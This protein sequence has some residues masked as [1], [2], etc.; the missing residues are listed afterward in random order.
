MKKHLLI[1]ASLVLGIGQ[2]FAD[3]YTFEVANLK[4]SLP[5]DNSKIN[6]PYTWKVSEVPVTVTL[7]KADGSTGTMNVTS[8]VTLAKNYTVT[9]SVPGEGTIDHVRITADDL[10]AFTATSPTTGTCTT[11]TTTFRWN[12]AEGESVSSVVFTTTSSADVTK[13]RVDYTPD[14]NY[15]PDVPVAEPLLG[16]FEATAID[17]IGSYTGTDPYVYDKTSKKYYALNNLGE[18]E[19]FGLYPEVSTLKVAGGSATQIEYIATV[20][21]NGTSDVPYINTNYIPKANTRIV[22][23]VDIAESSA[24]NWMAV[25]G[26]RQGGWTSHAFVLFART[27]KDN[28]Y[29]KGCYNRTGDEHVGTTEIPRDQ[30]MIIDAF[31]NTVTFSVNETEAARIEANGT[32]EDCTNNL[33]LFDTNTGGVG[34]NRRDNSY[35]FM[36]L[37]GCKIYEGD[38]LVRDFVP[39]VTAEGKG[40]LKDKV[41]GEIVL[42]ASN[43][44]FVL[45]PDGQTIASQAGIS[46]YPGKFVINTNDNHE[47]NWN[48]TDWVDLGAITYEAIDATNYQDMRREGNGGGWKCRFGYDETYNHIVNDGNNNFFNPYKGDGNWEPYQCTV[49][50]FTAGDAYRVSFKFSSNGWNSWS[51]YTELP[52][53]V[54]NNPEFDRALVPTS[55]SGQ[56]LGFVGLPNSAVENQPYS[57]KFIA[58]NTTATLAIQ[59]GVGDD[60]KDFFFRFNELTIDHVVY[61]E[62]YAI[63]VAIEPTT[64]E[65]VEEWDGTSDIILGSIRR[66]GDSYKWAYT[67]TFDSGMGYSDAH[68]NEIFGVPADD[69]NGKAWYDADYV[70]VNSKTESWIF[71]NNV[72][73]GNWPSNMGEVYVR[74][75]FK[76]EGELPE[77][78]YMPACHDDAPCEYYINGTLVWARNGFEPGVNGWYEDEIVKLNAEQRA[79]IKTDGSVN[80]F[81]YHVHQNWGGRYA[82]GGIYGNSMEEGSPSARFENN[83][84]RARLAVAIAQTEG[85]EGIDPEVLEY[86]QNATVCLQDAGRALNLIRYELRKALSPRHDYSFDSAEPADGLECWLYNVGAGQFLAGSNNWGTHTSLDYNISAWPMVLLANSSGENRYSIKTNLPNGLRG[87]NDGLGHNGYVDCGY[88]DDFTTNEGWAWTFEAVGNGNYRI[89]QSGLEAQEGKYLGMTDGEGY[90]VDTDKAGADNPYNQWKVV[91]RE[92]LEALAAEATAE[93]P[94]D[95]SYYIHQNTFSQNDF[96]GDNKDNANANLNDSKWECNAGEIFNWKGNDVNGDYV[97]NMSNAEGKV[98]IKQVITGLPAGQYVVECTGFYRDGSYDDAIAGNNRQL[99]YFYAGSEDNCT[100]LPSILDGA[101]LGAG[102]GRFNSTAIIPDNCAQAPRFFKLGTYTVQTPVVNVGNGEL[103]IGVY[104]NAEDVKAN[105]WIVLDNFRLYRVGDAILPTVTVSEDLY[106]TYVAPYDVDFTGAEVSAYA[107]QANKLKEGFV[108]LAPVTTVPAGTAVV[109]KAEAAGTYEINFAK[110]AEL[111]ADNDLVAAEEDVVASGTQY[112]LANGDDGIGFYKA[113]VGST[114]A[115]GKGYLVLSGEGVKPYYGFE[116]NATG[117]S[118]I[119]AAEDAVIYNLAG[120]RVSKAA[121]GVNIVNGK[122]VLK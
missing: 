32:V 14:E 17:A 93:N 97:F 110:D 92:Q 98:Y 13:I 39:I 12:P 19:E 63:D 53:F 29:N 62:K 8:S 41:T 109:V 81:A 56:V 33:F 43:K 94:A 102:Y 24:K 22:M 60:F 9:V 16:P 112:V 115:A 20:E 36:K 91:T 114:I 35:M 31:E 58:D 117:I 3:T 47:Y 21:A 120:Q 73:P 49:D 54:I 68:F 37:Y 84:T 86:A 85:V 7:A 116:N 30:R 99:A 118:G 15:I 48:G 76:A 83:E 87:E 57:F 2:L 38:A 72:L 46:V 90:Q 50:G 100:L 51:S 101:N 106:A 27:G 119:N 45:S 77:Q 67:M 5:A 1:L 121:K 70:M 71:G 96:D 107:A 105:D 74:R 6:L 26:A 23:D 52:F 88:G 65:Y 113:I 66:S 89:I 55:A 103:E 11:T 40:G 78:L 4:A 95:I 69:N 42:S 28:G 104:R 25:F 108:H 64:A 111:G 18:Y 59:F 79:L 61:P 10:T 82:D 80:V 44:D 34:E 75:Y 122:K